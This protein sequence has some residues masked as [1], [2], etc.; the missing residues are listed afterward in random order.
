MTQE[1]ASNEIKMAA[2]KFTYKRRKK[3][4]NNSDRYYCNMEVGLRYIWMT[5]L[6]ICYITLIHT[7]PSAQCLQFFVVAFLL[8]SLSLVSLWIHAVNK[9]MTLKISALVVW[10]SNSRRV[11]WRQTKTTQWKTSGNHLVHALRIYHNFCSHV[12]ACVNVFNSKAANKNVVNNFK[13]ILWVNNMRLTYNQVVNI[14]CRWRGDEV[15]ASHWCYW[16]DKELIFFLRCRKMN[17]RETKTIQVINHFAKH[18]DL[19]HL[20]VNASQIYQWKMSSFC[21]QQLSCCAMHKPKRMQ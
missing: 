11:T 3:S 10:V 20:M 2:F 18:A 4:E 6:A 7:R 19:I 9:G 8:A 1:I 5:H 12:H 21:K 17:E 15:C 16:Y 13:T 14:A